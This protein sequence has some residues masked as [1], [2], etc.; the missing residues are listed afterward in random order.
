MGIG[1]YYELIEKYWKGDFLQGH[2]LYISFAYWHVLLP[3]TTRMIN[4]SIGS[5]L[6]LD[7]SKNGLI[8]LALA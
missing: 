1:L 4:L 8:C 5:G 6:F 7:K 3:F 2:F